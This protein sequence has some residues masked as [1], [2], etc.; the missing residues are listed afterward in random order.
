MTASKLAMA[1][2]IVARIVAASG[3][4]VMES[5]N[6]GVI[7]KRPVGRAAAAALGDDGPGG[8]STVTVGGVVPNPRVFFTDP[9]LIRG[10]ELL[11]G[12]LNSFPNAIDLARG[13]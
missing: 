4:L 7:V 6:V 2:S 11:T 1:W 12:I 8:E 3:S 5:S 13:V 9:K 10:V